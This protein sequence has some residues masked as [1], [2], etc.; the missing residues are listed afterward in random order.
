MD[1]DDVEYPEPV[2]STDIVV[3]LA[4]VESAV[5]DVKSAIESKGSSWGGVVVVII[6]ILVWGWISDLWYSKW[7][8]ATAYSVETSDV[9]M[10]KKPHDCDFMSAPLGR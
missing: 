6:A 10:P 3:A 1:S 2:D 9:N 8:Y 5:R 7:R 4:E